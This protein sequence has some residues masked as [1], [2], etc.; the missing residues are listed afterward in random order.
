MKAA[1]AQEATDD[2]APT[3]VFVPRVT[4][5]ELPERPSKRAHAGRGSTGD[6][7]MLTVKEAAVLLRVNVKTVYA[8]LA[9]GRLKH[10]Q[11]G[12]RIIRIPRSVIASL[13]SKSA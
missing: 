12:S 13:I 7:E 5:P 1:Q 8:A 9:A 10:V 3:G 4:S 2:D 11:I 6:P